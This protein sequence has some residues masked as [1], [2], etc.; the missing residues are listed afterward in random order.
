MTRILN[1]AAVAATLAAALLAQP[2]Y[3]APASTVASADPLATPARASA[4]ASR[5]L[6]LA[7]VQ[8]GQRLVAVGE[9]GIV[10]YSDDKGAHW[11]QVAVP[12]T[13]TLTA[14]FFADARHGFAVG[15]DGVVLSTTDAGASW[16]KRL[17]GNALNTMLLAD[18]GQALNKARADAE[19]APDSS[20]A[21]VALQRADNRLQDVQAGAKFGPSRPWLGAWFRDANEGYVVGAYGQALT[22]HDGGAHWTSIAD[23]IDN[24]DGLHFNAISHLGGDMLAIAGEGGKVYRSSDGGAHWQTQDTGYQGQ[25]YGVTGLPGGAMLAYGFGGHLLRSEDGG[26]HWQALTS[27]TNRAL[28]SAAWTRSGTLLLATRD[29][30]ILRSTDQGRSFSLAAKGEGRELAGAVLLDDGGAAAKG[31]QGVLMALAGR[32]GVALLT[33]PGVDA[34]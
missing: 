22:T 29:G 10:L 1:T 13:V 7:V 26:E 24:P 16:S 11:L 20:A 14:V 32:R 5:A 3:G 17:D 25:L 33:L 28:I 21:K 18:A 2:L 6:M 31:R 23:R 19:R 15:H 30:G 34:K 4:L 12:V 27:P 8:A 9:R